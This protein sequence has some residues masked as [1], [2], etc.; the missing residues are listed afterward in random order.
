MIIISFST[1]FLGTIPI[2]LSSY[3]GTL[4]LSDMTSKYLAVDIR[5]AETYY[6]KQFS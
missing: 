3:L 5:V 1:S 2:F 4:N 6:T